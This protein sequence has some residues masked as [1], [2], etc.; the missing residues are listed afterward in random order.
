MMNTLQKATITAAI[1][2]AII[3][4]I[5]AAISHARADAATARADAAE[6]KSAQLEKSLED[7]QRTSAVISQARE[8]EVQGIRDKETAEDEAAAQFNEIR[9]DTCHSD[10]VVWLDDKL[11][12]L[13]IEAYRVAV[14]TGSTADNPP[15]PAAAGASTP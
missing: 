13:A 7:C 8:T 2:A 4:A 12:E 14:C 15:M 10:D 1:V 3:C 5:A 9:R 11:R 6:A